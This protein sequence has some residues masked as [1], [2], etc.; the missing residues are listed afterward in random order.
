MSSQIQN[1]PKRLSAGII[2]LGIV[3]IVLLM[4]IPLFVVQDSSFGGSDN[5]G[6]AVI[7]VIAPDYDSEWISN[8][9]APPGGETESMLFALQATV[10]GIL[11]G[12]LFGYLRGRKS[13]QSSSPDS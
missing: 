7:A 10:G 11:I 13:A 6:A 3:A 8:L 5:A 12:Y 9:W 2:I 4:V 1:Q